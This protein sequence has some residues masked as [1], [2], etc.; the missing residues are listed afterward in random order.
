MTGDY[1][2]LFNYYS[3]SWK[4]ILISTLL[5][6]SIGFIY[7][8]NETPKYN[9]S[10]ILTANEEDQQSSMNSGLIN[11]LVGGNSRDKFFIHE[12]RETLYSYDAMQALNSKENTLFKY[13]GS[14][15]DQEKQNYEEIINLKVILQKI[16][17]KFYGIDYEYRPNLYML[18]AF[19]KGSISI[20]YVPVSNFIIVSWLTGDPKLAQ[21]TV[22]ALLTETDE[23]FKARDKFELD[24][25]IEYLYGELKKNQDVI[26]INS[27]S[28]ILQSQLL[29]KSLVDSGGRY[30]FKTVRDFETSEYPVYPNFMFIILLFA[31]FGLFGSLA[32]KTYYFVFK[33]SKA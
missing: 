15:Y 17:F 30:K 31:S 9:V 12:F 21:S 32:Y 20:E 33:I 22:E 11:T 18:N 19:I 4:F 16:K 8:V 23:L 26:Q 13:F 10:I 25:K 7:V 1:V 5:L 28:R 6:G 29:K 3:K 27:V 24:A 2:P 14:L